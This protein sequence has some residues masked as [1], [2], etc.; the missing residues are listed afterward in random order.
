MWE[1]EEAKKGGK[2]EREREEEG[3]E[4]EKDEK[5]GISLFFFIIGP[6]PPYVHLASTHMMNAPQAFLIFRQSSTPVYCRR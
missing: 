2:K 3:K 4:R 5:S 6:L 1:G